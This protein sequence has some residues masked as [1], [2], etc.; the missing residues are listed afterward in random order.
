MLAIGMGNRRRIAAFLSFFVL[1]Q[2]FVVLGTAQRGEAAVTT[3]SGNPSCA[4][5]GL[6]EWHKDDSGSIEDDTHAGITFDYGDEKPGEP[7]EYQ[8]VEVSWDE[9]AIDVFAII[10]K[11]GNAA[12]VDQGSPLSSPRSYSTVTNLGGAGISHVT[13]CGSEVVDE[14]PT[15]DV[16]FRKLLAPA[17]DPAPQGTEYSFD[18]T[19]G[20]AAATATAVALDTWESLTDLEP[21]TT[22]SITET[23]PTGTGWTG[24]SIVCEGAQYQADGATATVEIV[25]DTTIDCT[26]TNTYEAPDEP[27]RDDVRP[28]LECVAFDAQA[29]AFTAHFGY[30]NENAFAVD[31]GDVPS[32]VSPGSFT[33]QFPGTGFTFEPRRSPFYPN[34]A[35]QVSWPAG[36]FATS[37][38][39]WALD[40]RTATANEGSTPCE[41]PEPDPE[42]ASLGDFVWYDLDRDG[43]QNDAAG[44]LGIEGVTV[45][46]TD[47]AGDPV[48]DIDGVLVGSTLTDDDGEYLFTNL[49]PGDY[50]VEF[51][52]STAPDGPLFS[53]SPANQGSDDAADSDAASVLGTVG[54]TD[55]VTLSAGETNLTVDAGLVTIPQCPLDVP[56]GGILVDGLYT[57][58]RP[59]VGDDQSLLNRGGFRQGDTSVTATVPAGTYDVT[60]V[61]FDEHSLLGANG[62]L[63]EQYVLQGWTDA[64]TLPAD[65]A[66]PDFSSGITDDLPDDQN[67][68]Q[69]TFTDVDV[70]V[71]LGWFST[72]HGN[73]VGGI[74]SIIPV[75]ALFVPQGQVEPASLGDFVWEDTD[76]DG[77]QDLGEPGVPGVTVNL[78]ESAGGVPQTQV[79]S[80][81]TD[82]DGEYRFDGLTPGQEYVVQFV[83]PDGWDG[84]SPANQGGNDAIDS[85]ADPTTGITGPVTLGS[86][87]YDPTIDAGLLPIV[88]E[89]ASLGDFVWLD[90]DGDGTQGLTEPGIE[91]VEVTLY[92]GDTVVATTT[93][94]ADGFYLF[95]GLTPG[96]EYQVGF[97]TPDGLFPTDP[98]QGPDTVDSDAVDGR[99]QVVVLAPGES[100]LTIDAGFVQLSII[101]LDGVCVNDGPFLDYV[102]DLPIDE[103]PFGTINLYFFEQGYDFGP[104]GVDESDLAGAAT[105]YEGVPLNGAV[106]WPGS[107]FDLGD[108]VNALD[109]RL[110]GP[111]AAADVVPTEPLSAYTPTAWPGWVLNADGTWSGPD[112]GDFA[113]L[114]PEMI[115]IAEVNP[116]SEPGTAFYP[117]RAE[118]CAPPGSL[119]D[120]VWFDIDRDG[121]QDDDV[122][123]FGEAIEPGVANV[124]VRLWEFDGSDFVL[125]ETTTTD[126]EGYYLFEGLPEGRYQVEFLEPTGIDF[127]GWTVNNAG[128]DDALDSDADPA[129]GL[130]PVIDLPLAGTDLTIDAGVL[131]EVEDIQ[132]DE[133][134]D[135]EEL[136]E[137]GYDAGRLALG[138]LLALGLGSLAVAMTRRRE[139]D[140]ETA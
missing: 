54:T 59:R 78:W 77:I 10:V 125:R 84:F 39:V 40:G 61:A 46:L 69:T 110:A 132:I 105:W 111:V 19:V 138:G 126:A 139:D 13:I 124:T 92:E 52:Y 62:Q 107:A 73:P 79:A 14:D 121:I 65:G 82:A 120:R 30:L 90:E 88:I 113:S 26:F 112:A 101:E 86:G 115:M 34:A 123:E 128:S 44:P 114:V 8:S 45:S 20:D 134:D 74:G 75:C 9:S 71:D 83:E 102:V 108:E 35:I 76:A 91:G 117:A 118:N 42:P 31:A 95:T 63:N 38:L 11:A 6:T 43:T 100:N 104:D 41:D 56:D 109:G 27:D 53:F 67:F 70:D 135:E 85:D 37:S 1:V 7:G 89:P 32:S 131:I 47:A 80:T 4:D 103:N 99:S 23:A 94:D 28:I 68:V 18:V 58:P 98:N 49:A 97:E 15:G 21:G 50:R 136:P 51:D 36:T 29:Q 116:L 72:R 96:V 133:D 64:P 5:Y 129:T 12:D 137:T 25:A 81:T 119:G 16:R 2:G 122:D 93:T 87:E 66:S 130:S 48:V 24:P 57:T 55:V 17:S 33:D 22:V 127:D 140:T 60:L 106:A 3:V